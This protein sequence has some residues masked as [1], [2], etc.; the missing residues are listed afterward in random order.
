[1]MLIQEEI[2]STELYAVPDRT[3][4]SGYNILFKI[5]LLESGN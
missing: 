3:V 5:K 4:N 1:M 2:F